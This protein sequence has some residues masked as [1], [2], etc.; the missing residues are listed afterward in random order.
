MLGLVH[1]DIKPHNIMLCD[2]G[3]EYDFVK[4]LDFGLVKHFRRQDAPQITG[5]F[6][7]SG[8]PLYLAP[9]LLV[10]PQV[11]D[12]R[13]DIY[14]F[15]IVGFNLLTGHDPFEGHSV[16]DLLT[17]HSTPKH[18]GQLNGPVNQFPQHSTS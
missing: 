4:V 14:A 7:I 10:E 6:Q 12:T 18:L 17:I 11:A 8:T 16:T 9:E 2:R 5:D 13:I 1:R 3:G 15:G